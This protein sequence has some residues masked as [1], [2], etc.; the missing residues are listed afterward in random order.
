[1]KI[2]HGVNAVQWCLIS[3][4]LFFA[5]CSADFGYDD[6]GDST[7]GT[8]SAAWLTIDP[9][10]QTTNCDQIALA[11]EAFIS[12]TYWH[13]CGGSAAEMTAVTVTW[14]NETTGETGSAAQSVKYGL[15][16]PLY[17]HRWSATL[18]LTMGANSI[19][20]TAADPK[21]SAVR[22]ITIT[23]SG[24]SLTASG[25]LRTTNGIGIG[26]DNSGLRMTLTGPPNRVVNVDT[27]NG[28]RFECLTPGS[29]TV[30]LLQNTFYYH[31]SPDSPTFVLDNQNVILADM[32]APAYR[33]HGQVWYAG[34]GVPAAGTLL[35]I[36]GWGNFVITSSD[37]GGNF[38]FVVPNGSYRIE[39]AGDAISP[40]YQDVTV[41][42][43]DA[44]AVNFTRNQ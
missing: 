28:Y 15:L 26:T 8:G 22:R 25:R 5:G 11:G 21:I 4:F 9:V 34:T 41:S 6:T 20:V 30:G 12:P 1:M 13:C 17:D 42:D 32:V 18:P 7:G 16:Y 2:K 31:F 14:R 35:K 44:P 39:S 38:E 33:V 27:L 43:A 40:S 19:A 36:S 3:L 24:L 37:A 23:R 29:Y 10:L